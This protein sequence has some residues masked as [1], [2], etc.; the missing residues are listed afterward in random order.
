MCI[1]GLCTVW[2]VFVLT[3]WIC[4][5]AQIRSFCL[6]HEIEN[7]IS[8]VQTHAIMISIW[9]FTKLECCAINHTKLVL[10]WSTVD[11]T[12]AEKY[13][14][15]HEKRKAT[16]VLSEIIEIKIL[17]DVSLLFVALGSLDKGLL[18]STQTYVLESHKN[19]VFVIHVPNIK[20]RWKL[21]WSTIWRTLCDTDLNRRMTQKMP[22]LKKSH[23]EACL[24]FAKRLIMNHLWCRKKLCDWIRLATIQSELCSAILALSTQNTKSIVKTMVQSR[25]VLLWMNCTSWQI[26]IKKIDGNIFCCCWENIPHSAGQLFPNARQN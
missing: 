17:V 7:H 20:K 6:Q 14:I 11:V 21:T 24:E 13:C 16:V 15:L 23:M 19:L 3:L 1:T 25:S 8:L 2:E 26:Q 10:R 4:Q 12:W 22:S 18:N 9:I 5:S